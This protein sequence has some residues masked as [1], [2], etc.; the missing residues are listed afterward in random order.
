MF[1]SFCHAE[2]G[3]TFVTWVAHHGTITQS[4]L[5]ETGK[6]CFGVTGSSE[7]LVWSYICCTRF[8]KPD[9][10]PLSLLHLPRRHSSSVLHLNMSK[11]NMAPLLPDI[12]ITTQDFA[13]HAF[14]SPHPTTTI[15][16]LPSSPLHE[17][18]AHPPPSRQLSSIPPQNRPYTP[19]TPS[20]TPPVPVK[21]PQRPVPLP[22]IVERHLIALQQLRS[23]LPTSY[24]SPSSPQP[25][26]VA[27]GEQKMNGRYK[28]GK[29]RYAWPKTR[30]WLRG[31]NAS[32]VL[33]GMV[34]MLTSRA[35]LSIPVLIAVS[36]SSLPLPSKPQTS[37]K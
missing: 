19:Y 27:G 21:S 15:K 14:S 7:R 4:H 31:I 23:Q 36:N 17:L 1:S 13:Y 32:L 3:K 9:L 29:E 2:S 8:E 33:S 28:R 11:S 18:P 34:I 20:P 35:E 16:P 6:C 24:Y 37:G 5:N 30:L 22:P 26:F 10:S 12:P 25:A